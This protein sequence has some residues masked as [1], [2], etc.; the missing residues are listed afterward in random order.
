MESLDIV[1]ETA[2]NAVIANAVIEARER[3]RLGESVSSRSLAPR[4]VPAD[5]RADDRRR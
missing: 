2:G 5:G 1:A 3:V 4:C